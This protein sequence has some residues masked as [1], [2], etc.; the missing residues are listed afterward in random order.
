MGM[1]SVMPELVR[2]TAPKVTRRLSAST[3]S[4]PPAALAMNLMD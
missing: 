3:G 4:R 1:H 2:I